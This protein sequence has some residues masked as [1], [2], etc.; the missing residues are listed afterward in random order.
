MPVSP[1]GKLEIRRKSIFD[2]TPKEKF[3][4]LKEV[5]M[6]KTKIYLVKLSQ[7]TKYQKFTIKGLG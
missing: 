5:F 7:K 3:K 1:R 2:L 4:M 6:I